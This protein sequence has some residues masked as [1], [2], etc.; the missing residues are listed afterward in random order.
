[1][2]VPQENSF[3]VERAGE[4]VLDAIFSCSIHSQQ[5]TVNSQHHKECNRN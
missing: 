5:S 2:P 3:F 4:P 1:M